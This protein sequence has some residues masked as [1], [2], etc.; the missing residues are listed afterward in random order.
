MC[1]ETQIELISEKENLAT[2]MDLHSSATVRT[3]RY[4]DSAPEKKFLENKRAFVLI[5]SS[6]MCRSTKTHGSLKN[7][8]LSGT[9]RQELL[10]I[11]EKRVIE[12]N[13][14]TACL[15]FE[16]AQQVSRCGLNVSTTCSELVPKDRGRAQTH[17]Q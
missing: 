13:F 1:F 7:V 15:A 16:T 9:F 12:T 6:Q 3:R 14:D 11:F 5:F 8:L 4:R 2:C 17:R 10:E